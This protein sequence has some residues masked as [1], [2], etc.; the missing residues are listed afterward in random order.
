L[1]QNYSGVNGDKLK[2]EQDVI[3]KDFTFFFV[4]DKLHADETR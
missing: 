1:A 2:I 3:L 4:F